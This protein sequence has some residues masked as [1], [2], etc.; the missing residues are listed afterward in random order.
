M[1][2]FM[3]WPLL[4]GGDDR[5]EFPTKQKRKKRIAKWTLAKNKERKELLIFSFFPERQISEACFQL[6]FL[7]HCS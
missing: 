5:P 2:S 6:S 4:Q 7:V 1:E 3:V